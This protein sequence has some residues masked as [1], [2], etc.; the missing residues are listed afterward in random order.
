MNRVVLQLG[1]TLLVAAFAGACGEESSTEP[2]ET[3]SLGDYGLTF[4]EFVDESTGW[5]LGR[6]HLN[7]VIAKTT[8]GGQNWTIRRDQYTPN[9]IV[10]HDH[11]AII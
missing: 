7:P 2:E 8:D 10:N 1:T 5:V 9:V 3:L 11:R 6:N 4:V